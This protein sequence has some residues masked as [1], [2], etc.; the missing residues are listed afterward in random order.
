ML[1]LSLIKNQNNYIMIKVF[2]INKSIIFLTLSIISFIYG[3]IKYINID[4]TDMSYED[5]QLFDFAIAYFSIVYSIFNLLLYI[6]CKNIFERIVDPSD[7]FLFKTKFSLSNM[8]LLL[9]VGIIIEL[10][11]GSKEFFTYKPIFC[12]CIGNDNHNDYAEAIFLLFFTFSLSLFSIFMYLNYRKDKE[13]PKSYLFL[14]GHGKIGIYIHELFVLILLLYS[15]VCFDTDISD[16][17]YSLTSPMLLLVCIWNI[18]VLIYLHSIRVTEQR[19]YFVNWYDFLIIA[20][21]LFFG[22]TLGH[23]ESKYEK[24]LG[25]MTSLFYYESLL[26]YLLAI[27]CILIVLIKVELTFAFY[28]KNKKKDEDKK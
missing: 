23:I 28:L 11:I 25:D 13:Q 2:P 1:V 18:L 7:K 20:I 21:L 15:F 5:Y 16:S 9:G 8:Y 17:A 22:Y 26:L 14:K 4:Y 19:K 6:F 3:A 27:S 24:M 12:Y 10:I